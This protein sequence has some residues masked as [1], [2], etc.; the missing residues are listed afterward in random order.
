VCACARVRTGYRNPNA[1]IVSLIITSLQPPLNT[2]HRQANGGT[3]MRDDVWWIFSD[4]LLVSST[5]VLRAVESMQID[6]QGDKREENTRRRKKKRTDT[7]HET[8]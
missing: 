1:F 3:Y 7:R 2:A 5:L 8:T 6:R 4:A